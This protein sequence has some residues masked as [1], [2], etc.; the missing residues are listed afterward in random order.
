MEEVLKFTF[1]HEAESISDF[2]GPPVEVKVAG[3][4][5]LAV[6]LV[7][8]CGKLQALVRNLTPWAVTF[9]KFHLSFGGLCLMGGG[10]RKFH[11]LQAM[12]APAYLGINVAQLRALGSPGV[13]LPLTTTEPI[14]IE[15]D[16]SGTDKLTE[17]IKKACADPAAVTRLLADM[18]AFD[19]EKHLHAVDEMREQLAATTAALE[20][21]TQKLTAA[22]EEMAEADYG[23]SAALDALKQ[24]TLKLKETEDALVFKTQQLAAAEDALSAARSAMQKMKD[25][26]APLVV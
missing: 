6:C 22:H 4:I 7:E 26:L 10:S 1:N 14:A 12:V 25:T 8:T 3:G 19:K 15:V 20:L 17:F 9:G 18:E 24:E 21:T 5:T 11:P 23:L 13:V 2:L 16:L